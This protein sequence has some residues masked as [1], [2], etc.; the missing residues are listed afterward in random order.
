MKN[1]IHL[2]R[3]CQA[4]STF[5]VISDTIITLVDCLHCKDLSNP[6]KKRYRAPPK[7]HPNHHQPHTYWSRFR[8]FRLRQASSEGFQAD[9][10]LW[11]SLQLPRAPTAEFL[12][13]NEK[14]FWAFPTGVFSVLS[15]FGLF[16]WMFERVYLASVGCSILFLIK[17]Q[18]VWLVMK[19][20]IRWRQ[21][22]SVIISPKP[23]AEQRSQSLDWKDKR[24]NDES[25][26]QKINKFQHPVPCEDGGKWDLCQNTLHSQVV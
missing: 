3:I 22:S 10:T 1:R 17:K 26:R 12:L 21:S 15:R 14:F 7:P 6:H 25:K 18:G 2:R 13:A 16:G 19:S 8:R 11:R 9:T 23:V 20:K 24:T 4:R 5:W